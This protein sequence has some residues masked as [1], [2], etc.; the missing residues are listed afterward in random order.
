MITDKNVQ[1]RSYIPFSI[2]LIIASSQIHHRASF[3]YCQL[4][5]RRGLSLFNDV[6]SRARR[7]LSPLTLYSDSA[8]LILNET[9]LNSDNALLALN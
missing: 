8:L 6:P 3:K 5:G 2:G 7:A 1:N 9:S 4:R